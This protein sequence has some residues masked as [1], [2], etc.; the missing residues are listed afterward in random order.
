SVEAVP[1]GSSV[2]PVSAASTEVVTGDDLEDGAAA[3]EPLE[4]VEPAMPE[5]ASEDET[6]DPIVTDGEASTEPADA[7]DEVAATGE[8]AEVVASTDVEP[9]VDEAASPPDEPS[10]A[11]AAAA[12]TAEVAE[13]TEPEDTAAEADAG[14]PVDEVA[15]TAATPADADDEVEADEAAEPD[16][17]A[18]AEAEPVD[19]PAVPDAT[20]EDLAADGEVD[21]RVEVAGNG[22][23]GESVD[24]VDER[25]EDAPAEDAAGEPADHP[26]MARDADDVAEPDD[27]AAEVGPADRPIGPDAT[28][29]DLAADG[30]DDALVEVAGNGDADE[31]V[32]AVD[33]GEVAAGGADARAEEPADQVTAPVDEPDE[34]A[35][36]QPHAGAAPE[37]QPDDDVPAEVPVAEE[38]APDEPVAE[39]VAASVAEDAPV[40]PVVEDAP[41]EEV[42]RDEPVAEEAPVEPVV[43]EDAPEA[44]VADDASP[45]DEV[46]TV[47]AAAPAADAETAPVGPD[48]SPRSAAMP[49]VVPGPSSGPHDELSTALLEA[50]LGPPPP[51]P[52]T[53]PEG[54][55]AI[56]AEALLGAGAHEDDGAEDGLIMAEA[57]LGDDQPAARPPERAEPATASHPPAAS[58]VPA[59]PAPSPQP[60]LSG[61]ARTAGGSGRRPEGTW[62]LGSLVQ[63]GVPTAVLRSL[64]PDAFDTDAG[65]MAAVAAAIGAVVPAPVAAPSVEHPVVTRGFS[66][67]AVV[68]MLDSGVRGVPPSVIEIDGVVV[69]ATPE[70]LAR[71]LRRCSSR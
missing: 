4:D 48:L 6:G 57:L 29:E 27:V 14:E 15:E 19:R 32:D 5:P 44:P 45:E 17:A 40:A 65:S 43:E 47:D 70:E 62:S 2:C 12:D 58:A 33:E 9:V 22:D 20:V 1:A 59:P 52:P 49:G 68:A 39:Q 71:A 18:E 38:V 66:P 30:A 16:V 61:A 56:L 36:T 64:S 25:V 53:G 54:D 23:A 24:A 46:S 26:D 69:P 28:A 50:L 60:T 35:V 34:P 41:D 31:S 7:V 8:S 3:D 13:P 63:L 11:D 37:A 42:A 51:P 55:G 10:D 67:E 21:E